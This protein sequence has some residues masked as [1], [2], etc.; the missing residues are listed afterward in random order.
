MT[1]WRLSVKFWGVRGSLPTPS[2]QNMDFGGNTSCV[3]VRASTGESIIFDAGSG[4]RELGLQLARQT[5]NGGLDIRL[6]FSHFHWDHV[7]GLPFFVPIYD[8]KNS[9]T[10]YSARYSAPLRSSMQ[11]VMS[12]PYFPV[13]FESLPAHIELVEMDKESV[14]VGGM[15]VRSFPVCHPQG[16]CGYRVEA[17]GAVVV[18]VPDREP[19]DEALDRTVREQ[20]KGADLL[21]HDGQ[22]TPEEYASHRGWG[23]STWEEGVRIA[24]EAGIK[25]LALFH[26][27]PAHSDDIMAGIAE[28]AKSA[29][30]GTV[31]AME[32]WTIEV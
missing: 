25:R 31:A 12:A 28:R 2:R 22:Y 9:I 14:Q 6:F 19:G 20:S 3:E 4:I 10:L 15:Q 26:H 8:K 7:I 11:G 32:G 29:F 13:E 30:P 23:H 1:S 17:A 16:A 21:I 18:Y 24:C 5:R 27:D